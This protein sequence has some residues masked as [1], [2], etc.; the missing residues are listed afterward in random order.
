MSRGRNER[1]SQVRATDT[2]LRQ[3]R[4][5]TYG[6]WVAGLLIRFHCTFV[7]VYVQFRDFGVRPF[8]ELL[9]ISHLLAAADAGS[10]LDFLAFPCSLL[11]RRDLDRARPYY[12]SGRSNRFPLKACTFALRPTTY[13]CNTPITF[14]PHSS[15]QASHPLW[16]SVSSHL[17]NRLDDPP[18]SDGF[19]PSSSED[20]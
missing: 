8:P 12:P 10:S 9:N 5:E 13:P 16:E 11:V 6:G 17:S 3:K 19:S 18:A 20:R 15:R 4:H 1:P 14:I 2:H 7:G